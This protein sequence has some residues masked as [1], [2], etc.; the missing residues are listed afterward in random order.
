MDELYTRFDAT[1]FEKTRLSIL[2]L[3]YRMGKASYGFLKQTLGQTDGAIYA[4]LEKL[5]QARYLRKRRSVTGGVV[6]TDYTMT[7][8]GREA[9]QGYLTFLEGVIRARGGKEADGED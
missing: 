6:K 9:F 2:T 5:V 7:P 8:R 3:V 4:H 1:F